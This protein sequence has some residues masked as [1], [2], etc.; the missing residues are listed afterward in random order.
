MAEIR[1]KMLRIWKILFRHLN[2]LNSLFRLFSWLLMTDGLQGFVDCEAR[3]RV[4]LLA[5]LCLAAAV[6]TGSPV[7]KVVEL[8]KELK[9][10][11]DTDP[12]IASKAQEL[13]T[14]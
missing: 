7:E 9:T 1:E 11:Y 13:K 6:G 12:N 8:I 4:F 5:Q 3:M 2:N 14:S 10:E